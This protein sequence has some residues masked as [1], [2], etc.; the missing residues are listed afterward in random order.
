MA[1]DEKYVPGKAEQNGAETR[2][3]HAELP[4]K[5][6]SEEEE[7]EEEEK[8]EEYQA[9]ECHEVVSLVG[10]SK[11]FNY[12]KDDS[13]QTDFLLGNGAKKVARCSKCT[14]PLD[15][16]AVEA[17]S[18]SFALVLAGATIGRKSAE[19]GGR[20]IAAASGGYGDADE[21]SWRP[22]GEWQSDTGRGGW[23][24]KG[25]R[26][27]DGG[28]SALR[29]EWLERFQMGPRVEQKLKKKSGETKVLHFAIS[30]EI[31]KG[32]AAIPIVLPKPVLK[33]FWQPTHCVAV[34]KLLDE[35]AE[36]A[37][38]SADDALELYAQAVLQTLV[39][40]YC[41]S[42]EFKRALEAASDS[43]ERFQATALEM[44]A[45]ALSQSGDVPEA[46]AL[47]LLA[48][49][50]SQQQCYLDAKDT[51]AQARRLFARAEDHVNEAS[52]AL[53]A[54][55]LAALAG[56]HAGAVLMCVEAQALQGIAAL[57]EILKSPFL[58]TEESGQLND[59]LRMMKKEESKCLLLAVMVNLA[60]ANKETAAA[61]AN[62][63]DQSTAERRKRAATRID[64]AEELAKAS[65]SVSGV[66]VW[67]VLEL[68]VQVQL[69]RSNYENAL[70]KL[71]TVWLLSGA[72]L[73]AVSLA[74]TG[75][76]N[77]AALLHDNALLEDSASLD[78]LADQDLQLALL[79]LS[80]NNFHR[81]L[82]ILQLL[83]EAQGDPVLASH[84]RLKA[85][86]V[87]SEKGH[88]ETARV[89]LES[90]ADVN[91]GFYTGPTLRKTPLCRACEEGHIEVAA[92]RHKHLTIVQ[93]LEERGQEAPD[94]ANSQRYCLA[95]QAIAVTTTGTS[96]IAIA[97]NIKIIIIII[98]IIITI[99]LFFFF[100]MTATS[101]TAA[102]Q[103]TTIRIKSLKS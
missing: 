78:G 65:G 54:S 11:M 58:R 9:A 33:R 2:S 42:K 87:A 23:T 15:D 68:D 72:R 17:R 81:D 21:R 74:E 98:I 91:E 102:E 3:V 100:T 73:D 95:L 8:Q 24:S 61:N 12:D 35:D 52:A 5:E 39:R 32:D 16:A 69:Q 66:P 57:S 62:E 89:L 26:W 85:L 101:T 96:T 45:F 47:Q 103:T 67:M 55:Q 83:L 34:W 36:G 43:L 82:E 14:R 48:D 19:T 79:P 64:K 4:G 27:K 84:R 37:A 22:R 20:S 44:M 28:A 46:V 93:L 30:Q 94:R 10:I 88:V 70:Q 38:V 18:A 60:I 86:C 29:L 76:Q 50:Q 41:A 1:S 92:I 40:A 63:G 90:R 71:L 49:C 97:T 77:V 6:L 99:M 56:D 53:Q 75:L 80:E 51:V 25:D 7:K 31:L 13:A 59:A